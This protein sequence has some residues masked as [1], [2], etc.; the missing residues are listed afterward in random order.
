[1]GIV[2]AQ[3][4]DGDVFVS[5]GCLKITIAA[6]V[7]CLEFVAVVKTIDVLA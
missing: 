2:A 5:K 4:I 6:C 3:D 1:M 7:E